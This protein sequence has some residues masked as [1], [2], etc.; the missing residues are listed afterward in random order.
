MRRTLSRYLYLQTTIGSVRTVLSDA[1]AF[2]TWIPWLRRSSLLARDDRSSVV[3][4]EAEGWGARPALVEVTQGGGDE[5]AFRQIGRYRGR[6]VAGTVRLERAESD[7]VMVRA[8]VTTDAGGLPFFGA[9]RVRERVERLLDD[10][11]HA[12]DLRTQKLDLGS[13]GSGHKAKLKLLEIRETKSGLS[14]WF[15]GQAYDLRLGRDGSRRGGGNSE[16]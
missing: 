12:L 8:S 15:A 3:E 5:I 7:G 14:V 13:I 9:R 6:G 2:A 16:R 1:E 10:G 4:L 11:L